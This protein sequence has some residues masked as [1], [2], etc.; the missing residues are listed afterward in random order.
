MGFLSRLFNQSKKDE[1]TS[2]LPVAWK[3]TLRECNFFMA[4]R[5]VAL[6]YPSFHGH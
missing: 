2:G 4:R 1:S 6:S 3:K 5:G